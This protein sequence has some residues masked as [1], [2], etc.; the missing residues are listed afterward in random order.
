MNPSIRGARALISAILLGAG[1][2][3]YAA[4]FDPI[5]THLS[6]PGQVGSGD[7]NPA[8]ACSLP[9]DIPHLDG[10][11]RPAGRTDVRQAA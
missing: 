3:A 4:R 6:L 8:D 11:D 9:C 7:I 5:S 10:A 1:L 2:S